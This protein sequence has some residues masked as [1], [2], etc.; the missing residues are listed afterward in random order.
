MIIEADS[1]LY[2]SFTNQSTVSYKISGISFGIYY[3]LRYGIQGVCADNT[4]FD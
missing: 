3:I 2:N 1:F 4:V